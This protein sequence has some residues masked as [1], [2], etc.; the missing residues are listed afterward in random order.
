MGDEEVHDCTANNELAYINYQKAHLEKQLGR[1][2]N[3]ATKILSEYDQK[4][5][6]VVEKLEYL[7]FLEK[8]LAKK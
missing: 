6:E 5:N 4:N 2:T 7:E 8:E 3:L 1:A